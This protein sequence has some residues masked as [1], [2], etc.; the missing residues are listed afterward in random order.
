MI[1]QIEAALK[2]AKELSETSSDL[3]RKRHIQCKAQG[4]P[5]GQAELI[6]SQVDQMI[7]WANGSYGILSERDLPFSAD[8][9][10][11]MFK[12]MDRFR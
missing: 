4:L 2:A 1:T 3:E 11:W 8:K 12:D 6:A 10:I 5:A 7:E 9:L